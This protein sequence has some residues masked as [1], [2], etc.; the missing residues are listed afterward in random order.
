MTVKAT[1][2][3]IDGIYAIMEAS[4]P[5][6]ERRPKAEQTSLFDNPLYSVY[7]YK[8][9]NEI[10]GFIAIWEFSDFIFT[11]HLAVDQ[12]HRNKKIGSALITYIAEKYGKRICLEVEPP[13][14]SITERRV[15]FYERLGFYFNDYSY[16]QPPI[17]KGKE[18]IPLFIMST[19]SH[20]NKSE[21][22]K[23]RDT[24]YEKVYGVSPAFAL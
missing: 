20:L 3:D 5:S 12:K 23:T 19:R 2:K 22:D 1:K 9:E 21:F 10:I 13:I 17:S 11:E 7:V 14:D 16:V 8:E 6:D 4:F 24:L 18:S 15:R